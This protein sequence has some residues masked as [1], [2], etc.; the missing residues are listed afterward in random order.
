[1]D[2]PTPERRL[3][4]EKGGFISDKAM[5]NTSGLSSNGELTGIGRCLGADYD[6]ESVPQDW[7]D[8]I[9]IAINMPSHRVLF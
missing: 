7:R 8:G 5:S 9:Q 2:V 1:M 3:Q 4:A 6:I